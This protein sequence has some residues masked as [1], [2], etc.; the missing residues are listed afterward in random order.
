MEKIRR[1]KRE[2]RIAGVCGGLARAIGIDAAYIRLAW[3]A[4]AVVPPFPH[5]LIILLYA[6][7]AV[8]IPEEDVPGHVAETAG[9]TLDAV[10]RV[11]EFAMEKGSAFIAAHRGAAHD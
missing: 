2:K 3:L 8:I 7:L 6:A 11:L 9:K 4:M 1:L 10:G 5:I